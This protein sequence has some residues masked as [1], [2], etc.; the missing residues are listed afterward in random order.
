M[1]QLANKYQAGSAVRNV[2]LGL[3]LVENDGVLAGAGGVSA[4]AVALRLFGHA[5]HGGQGFL[6]GTAGC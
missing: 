5:D 2:V 6:T 3:G 4:A 1:Q